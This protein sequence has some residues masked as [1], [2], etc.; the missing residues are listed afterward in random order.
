MTITTITSTLATGW[1]VGA[2]AARLTRLVVTDDL[3]DRLIQEPVAAF[4]DDDPDHPLAAL[5]GCPWCIGFWITLATLTIERTPLGRTA[6][7]RLLT[8]ALAAHWTIT[9][10]AGALG[11]YD[12]PEETPHA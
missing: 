7:W 1:R 4:T 9:H 8:T 6:V 12:D 3:G 5:V 10:I 11:D 2:A